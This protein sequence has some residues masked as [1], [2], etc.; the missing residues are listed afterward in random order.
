MSGEG[1]SSNR[2][3]TRNSKEEKQVSTYKERVAQ[4]TNKR[5]EKKRIEIYQICKAIFDLQYN[6]T[7]DFINLLS[8][9]SVKL[10]ILI[11]IYI[12]AFH[13]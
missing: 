9:E 8:A 6:L 3:W 10:L 5:S 12:F 1:L 13:L 11:D 2:G 4:K 7:K